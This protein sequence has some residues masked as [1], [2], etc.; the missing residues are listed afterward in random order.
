MSD[1]ATTEIYTL[2]LHD[3]LPISHGTGC[4][5]VYSRFAWGRWRVGPDSRSN[6]LALVSFVAFP[7]DEIETP[8]PAHQGCSTLPSC[9]PIRQGEA[10]E[11]LGRPVRHGPSAFICVHLRL[12]FPGFTTGLRDVPQIG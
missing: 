8:P 1:S 3:A 7:D 10:E 2:S 4:Y 6:G 12:N 9:A 11:S 5:R